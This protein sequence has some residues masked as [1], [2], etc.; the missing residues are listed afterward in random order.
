MASDGNTHV[1]G[2]GVE[3]VSFT[4]CKGSLTVTRT[5]LSAFA[6]LSDVVRIEGAGHNVHHDQPEALAQAIERFL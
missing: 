2:R 6:S 4:C 1:V 3:S 5:R